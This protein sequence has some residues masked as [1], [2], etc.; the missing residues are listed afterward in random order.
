MALVSLHFVLRLNSAALRVPFRVKTTA[1]RFRAL[2]VTGLR[3]MV[4]LLVN[5]A[6]VS[7]TIFLARLAFHPQIKW[8]FNGMLTGDT[9]MCLF[10]ILL[11]ST[12][13]SVMLK[14]LYSCS[15]I[16]HLCNGVT[17]VGR[18]FSRNFEHKYKP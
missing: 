8:F 5:L 11:A 16:R 18:I 17:D 13:S 1:G 7:R 15:R 12:C 9:C 3:K 14:M 10:A 2:P 6:V 4:V